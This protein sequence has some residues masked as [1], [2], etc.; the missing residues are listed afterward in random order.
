M[1]C[2]LNRWS[3]DERRPHANK[4]DAFLWSDGPAQLFARQ[5]FYRQLLLKLSDDRVVRALP[6]F[7]LPSWKLPTSC[8]SKSGTPPSD[9]YA[10]CVVDYDRGGDSR[11]GAH[12]FILAYE[13]LGTQPPRVPACKGS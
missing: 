5:H 11:G 8:A 2:T 6:C 7:E 1:V 10:A 13:L 3:G 12:C 4:L 9:E